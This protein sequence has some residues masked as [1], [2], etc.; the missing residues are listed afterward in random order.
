[1]SHISTVLKP[2]A[3]EHRYGIIEKYREKDSKNIELQM[4]KYWVIGILK[5]KSNIENI[6]NEN[7]MRIMRV[8]KY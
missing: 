6:E 1:M 8:L 3:A 4:S 7:T 2:A 5:K